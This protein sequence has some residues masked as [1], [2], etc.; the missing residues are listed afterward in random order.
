[1]EQI[2][3]NSTLRGLESKKPI[4][5]SKQFF[6]LYILIKEASLFHSPLARPKSQ[7][8][9]EHSPLV[10]PRSVPQGASIWEVSPQGPHSHI[11][12]TGGG[13]SDRGSY[14]IPKNIPTSEFVYSKKSLSVFASANCIIYL[15]ES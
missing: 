7:S 8:P 11:L 14:F 5:F 9:S 1:M 2:G 4:F 10:S 15:L 13:G 6:T 12:M 3:R